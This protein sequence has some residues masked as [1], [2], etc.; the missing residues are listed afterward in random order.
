[1]RA[2]K[3][4]CVPAVLE[5]A[6]GFAGAGAEKKPGAT[7]AACE[8]AGGGARPQLAEPGCPAVG[9]PTTPHDEGDGAP[10]TVPQAAAAGAGACAGVG[11]AAEGIGEGT[12]AMPL[13][14]QPLSAGGAR[15][16]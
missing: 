10:A 9:D 6:S 12:V 15:D 11:T 13:E 5:S 14:D 1:M 7:G 3:G 16:A 2:A 8:C 4:S